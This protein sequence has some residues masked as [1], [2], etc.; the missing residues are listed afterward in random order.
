VFH[1]IFCYVAGAAGVVRVKRPVAGAAAA[2]IYV[3]YSIRPPDA[4][5]AAKKN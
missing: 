5:R 2:Q 3:K 1:F 4:C